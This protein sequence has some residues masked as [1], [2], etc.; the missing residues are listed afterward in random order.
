[1][2]LVRDQNATD[3]GSTS[4]VCWWRSVPSPIGDLAVAG[5]RSA[6]RHVR[7]PGTWRETDLP[8]AWERGD[9]ELDE[10]AAQLAEY[11]A[12][13]RTEFTL[14][15]AP[16]GT[17]FQQRVWW[18]LADIDFGATATYG[19]IAATVGNPRAS[20]A[21]GMANNRNPIALFIPCHRV[22]GANGSLTGYGGGIEMKSWLLAHEQAVLA[23]RRQATVA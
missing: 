11:F 3:T 7:L 6:L 9:G 5:D 14:A 1:M 16:R 8:A 10:A 22:I 2:T 23:A 18:A 4:E 17:A 15:L 21:V 13:E 12:G 19:E 20:R